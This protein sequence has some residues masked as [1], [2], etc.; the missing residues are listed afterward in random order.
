MQEVAAD[1]GAALDVVLQF[2]AQIAECDA[3]AVAN[4]KQ[5]ARW[6]FNRDVSE[7][8]RFA[9]EVG[10]FGP[11]GTQQFGPAPAS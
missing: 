2:A 8:G 7:S 3:G 4:A 10:A 1:A 6:P 11:L 5:I 9:V